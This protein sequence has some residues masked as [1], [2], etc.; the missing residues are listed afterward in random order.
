VEQKYNNLE[1]FTILVA[2]DDAD[3]RFLLHTAFKENKLD[4]CLQ[5]VENGAEAMDY[6]LACRDSS[7]YPKLIL[8]DLNM[9]KKD[10]REVL[11]EV[12]KCA[13]LVHIP[14]V[15]FSTTHNEREMRTCYELGASSYIIKPDNFE[16]L[17]HI[18]SGIYSRWLASPVGAI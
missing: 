13:D 17:R 14:I 12:K 2:E 3:D 6:L 8:L 15:I 9:P 11:T 4:S 7:V 16:K 1:P 10:G 18:I 5:F